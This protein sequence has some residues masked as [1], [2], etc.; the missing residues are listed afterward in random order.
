VVA[1]FF[2]FDFDPRRQ[3]YATVLNVGANQAAYI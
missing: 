3:P 2:A 1:M